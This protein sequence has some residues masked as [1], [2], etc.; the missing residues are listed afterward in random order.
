MKKIAL[1][2]AALAVAASPAFAAP[3]YPTTGH[4]NYTLGGAV[5]PY[6]SVGS[7][8]NSGT[9]VT[10]SSLFGANLIT[11]N[12][13]ENVPTGAAQAWN[14]HIVLGNSLCNT[15]FN[16][17][18]GSLGGG[19]AAVLAGPTGP[20]FV[21]KEDYKVAIA[22]GSNSSSNNASTLGAA[23]TNVISHGNPA[24]GNFTI[25]LAS[26]NPGKPLVAGAYADNLNVTMSIA[27]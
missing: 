25:D 8:T 12:S 11:I 3:A 4:A 1:L 21:N 27:L 10:F 20:D 26:I 18:A 7:A 9:N 5:L 15:A 23:G 14:A 17:K 6:C 13:L 19:L 2:S 24:V 22:F 16:V